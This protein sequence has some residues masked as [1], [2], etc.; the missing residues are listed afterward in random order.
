MDLLFS[1]WNTD[2]VQSEMLDMLG[3]NPKQLSSTT[4]RAMQLQDM[5]I[6]IALPWEGLCY[7]LPTA[8]CSTCL[9]GP[10]M[11]VL[12]SCLGLNNYWKSPNEP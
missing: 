3:R 12:E 2:W 6:H 5:E 4:G 8:V 9:T 1:H 7:Y 11:S 10:A